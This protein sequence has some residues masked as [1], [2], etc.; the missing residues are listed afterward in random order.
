[1]CIRDSRKD[2]WKYIE[3]KS[4]KSKRAG[5][6]RLYNLADDPAERNDMYKEKSQIAKELAEELDRIRRADYTR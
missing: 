1:M 2:N 4:P 6:P 5:T 3:N